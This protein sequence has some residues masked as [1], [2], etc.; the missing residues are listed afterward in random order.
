MLRTT[1]VAQAQPGREPLRGHRVQS[2]GKA[3]AI[4]P[5]R[6]IHQRGDACS[7]HRFGEVKPLAGIRPHIRNL[8]ALLSILD[9]FAYDA[10]PDAMS[11]SDD[12]GDD[13]ICTQCGVELCD[14]CP[15]Y[16]ERI[17]RQAVEIP[18]RRI[19]GPKIV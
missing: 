13:L 15:V 9:A 4:R 10:E 5:S 19:P 6:P 11:E 17:D 8:L 7:A 12:R 14:K 1:E 3:R 16:L 2:R 18:E